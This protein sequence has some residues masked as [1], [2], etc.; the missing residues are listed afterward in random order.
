[1]TTIL[2]NPQFPSGR[3]LR[4]TDEPDV[5]PAWFAAQQ[6]FEPVEASPYSVDLRPLSCISSVE[7]EE[8][9]EWVPSWGAWV[10]P[11]A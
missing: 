11:R 9:Q 8:T 3:L 4:I 5:W 6:I 1:M 7:Q 10:K 2:R